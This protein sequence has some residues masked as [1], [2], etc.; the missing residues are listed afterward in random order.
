[1]LKIGLEGALS[2]NRFI[3]SYLPENDSLTLEEALDSSLT[4]VSVTSSDESE[5]RGI[6][7]SLLIANAKVRNY[8]WQLLTGWNETDPY[9]TPTRARLK[10]R[11][12]AERGFRFTSK[13]GFRIGIGNPLREIDNFCDQLISRSSYALCTERDIFADGEIDL[14]IGL[15]QSSARSLPAPNSSSMLFLANTKRLVV[16]IVLDHTV[17]PGV[18]IVAGQSF[19]IS[20]IASLRDSA[21]VVLKG[22]QADEVWSR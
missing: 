22:S 21:S 5:L 18:V 1:M 4:R 17:R 9:L 14:C 13:N 15:I 10:E 8:K 20:D 19:D 16:F 3:Y 11:K 6:L 7:P 2:R 12:L